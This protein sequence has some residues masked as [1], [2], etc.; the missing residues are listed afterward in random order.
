MRT[1]RSLRWQAAGYTILTPIVNRDPALQNTALEV[2]GLDPLLRVDMIGFA[3]RFVF[4][5]EKCRTYERHNKAQERH[6]AGRQQRS[7]C[8]ACPDHEPS[9]PG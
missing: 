7:Q 6:D 8:K 3:L 1:P 2:S 4:G 5:Q 9:H